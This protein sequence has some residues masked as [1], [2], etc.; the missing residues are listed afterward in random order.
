[1]SSFTISVL[2]D[3][4]FFFK[5]P[6][7]T[8]EE[9]IPKNIHNILLCDSSGSMGS[10]WAKVASGWNKLVE[11]LDGSV[12]LILFSDN[13]F[14]YPGKTLPLH[15]VKSG[16]TDIISGLNELEKEL[17]NHKNDDL[18]R[19]FFITDG[20]DGKQDT[21]QSRFD[22]TI[23]KY[24]KPINQVEFYVLGLTGNFPVFI[25]QAIRANIHSG[26]NSIPNLFWSQTCTEQEI[27]EEFDLIGKQNKIINKITLPFVG[28]TTPF[29]TETNIFYTGDWVLI[30]NKYRGSELPNWFECEGNVYKL[31]IN[32]SHTFD[33]LLEMFAQW[34][35]ILQTTSI[36]LA[37]DTNLIKFNATQVKEQIE[38][39]YNDFISTNKIVP[40]MKTFTQRILD[41]QIKT[42]TYQYQSYLKIANDLASGVKLQFMNNIELAKQLKGVY[43]GKYSEKAFQ[44]R[45][46]TDEDFENDKN[47]FIKVLADVLPYLKDIE[48][49]EH[50]VITLDNTLDIIRSDGFIDTLKATKSKIE[51]L[52]NI[53]ITGNGVLL[54]ITDAATINP[55]VTQIKD[56]S[57]HCAVLS[58]TAIEDLIDNPPPNAQLTQYEKDNCVVAIQ[59]GEGSLE[60]V[61]CVIPLFTKKVAEVM[62]PIIRSNLFQLICTYSIQKSP[63]TLNHNAHLG[64]LSGLLGYLLTKPKSEWRE[65]TVNKIRHTAGIYLNRERLKKFVE[66]LWENPA[67]AV[68][69]E[70]PDEEIKCESITKLLLMIL[71]ST[72]DKTPEQ[73]FEVMSHV[74]K[75]YIGR[76]IGNN[77]N[78]SDWFDLENPEDLSDNINFPDFESIY[79]HGFTV[80]ETKKEI[81]K[82]IRTYK[83]DKPKNLNIKLNIDKL[84]DEWNGGSV[85]NISW[86]GLK[87]FTNSIGYEITDENIFQYVTHGLIHSGSADRMNGVLTY[88][89]SKD[90]VSNELIGI[91]FAKLRE[92]VINDYKSKASDRYFDSFVS[93]HQTTLPMSK[94]DIIEAIIKEATNSGIQV[95][96]DTFDTV[97]QFNP[98]NKL[99]ANACMS[100][101]CPYYLIPRKDF[102]AH[103][104][105][106][107]SDPKFIHSFHRT[108]Y[109]CKNKPINKIIDDLAKGKFRPGQYT[110]QPIQISKKILIE[111]YSG[112]VEINKDIYT[113]IYND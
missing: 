42:K 20:A 78:V 6:E 89:E 49:D 46:H 37:S 63:F 58:T 57:T 105:R 22:K 26:R 50:C 95:S 4:N 102:S 17:K 80:M 23:N 19:V 85:G 48:S 69:T 112:D 88:E 86:K 106:M 83:F 67:R 113:T 3:G 109:A 79:S 12:S 94:E 11:K 98:D 97:Y 51:F 74:W 41:K 47:E 30:N 76:L 10:Y 43:V 5:V 39:I 45:S 82:A 56:V 93:E 9:I 84:K 103:I 73:I 92:Q 65:K 31:E 60:K 99:L 72:K 64:A 77:N 70:I 21:F 53:G 100:K 104:E 14:R 44:L 108:V 91:K 25:S 2:A 96:L 38:K 1:M 52:Q 29:S 40:Q 35:G 34:I 54:N 75:E 90:W 24:Y 66:T 111:K 13:A 28:K 107:K 18:V 15:M 61:N 87:V 7:V 110:N 33:D 32:P 62:G 101:E 36:K 59:V 71:V 68:V 55:W 27:N 81:E 8:Q 16:G